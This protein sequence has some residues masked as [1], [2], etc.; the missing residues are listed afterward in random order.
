MSKISMCNISHLEYSWP[1]RPMGS[2]SLPKYHQPSSLKEVRGI[3]GGG[4]K[5]SAEPPPPTG[6]LFSMLGLS[7][8]RG[9]AAYTCLYEEQH[10]TLHVNVHTRVCDTYTHRHKPHEIPDSCVPSW[11][12]LLLPP[13]HP[14]LILFLLS[15][16]VSSTTAILC[17]LSLFNLHLLS[18]QA[19]YPPSPT[20]ERG[21]HPCPCGGHGHASLSGL[22]N[23]PRSWQ[24]G[25][26]Q[27]PMACFFLPRK[28]R[29]LSS[30]FSLA[31]VPHD[32]G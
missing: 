25:L 15:T 22:I 28:T 2:F 7:L 9:S 3:R 26:H 24:L 14:P 29:I 19:F 18:S 21:C 13:P 32:Q 17:G 30:S 1:G 12:P 31:V 5:S 11:T 8:K 4:G 23:H 6:H 20:I 10:Q 16:S 27:G